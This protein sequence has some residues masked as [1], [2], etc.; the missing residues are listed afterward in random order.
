M[1]KKCKGCGKPFEP[2][3]STLEAF[4][5]K[6]CTYTHQKKESPLKRIKTPIPKRSKKKIVQDLQYSV[7]R[8]E[9]LG[10]PENRFCPITGKPAT[11]VHH[12]AG[13]LGDLYLDTRYWIAL[14]REG[15]RR[16]EENPEW[17]KKNGYSLDRLH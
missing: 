3:Y 13:R 15:H 6:K 7:L 10:K 14:S 12:M 4:C 16:V 8:K 9:F 5:S 2:R 1:A 17:A 11:D